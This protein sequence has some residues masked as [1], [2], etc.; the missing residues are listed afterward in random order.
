MAEDESA[1]ISFVE[2]ADDEE[3]SF[4]QNYFKR[5]AVQQTYL[6]R[7]KVLH[8]F[9][10]HENVNDM[11]VLDCSSLTTNYVIKHIVA[12]IWPSIVREES[13]QCDTIKKGVDFLDIA[14]GI[15]EQKNHLTCPL[16]L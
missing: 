13:C 2:W 8:K 12:P 4:V 7:N 15:F 9:V 3:R 10:N 14:S 11:K 1:K 6:A 16:Q 5:G